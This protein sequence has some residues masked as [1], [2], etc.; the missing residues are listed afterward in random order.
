MSVEPP[1]KRLKMASDDTKVAPAAAIETTD[2]DYDYVVIGGGSGGL[3][4][5]K[6]AA[7]NGAR[8]ALFDF[9]QP[10]PQG[11]KW[12]LGGTCVNVGCIPKKLFHY[13]GLLKRGMHD[14]QHLGWE[15]SDAKL[16]WSKLTE[17]VTD[18]IGGI[19]WAYK[20]AL[21]D[22]NVKYYNSYAQLIDSHTI[23]FKD[24]KV[25]KKQKKM[26]RITA[27]Y[28]L[29]AT[30]GRPTMPDIPGAEEFGI[31][32]DDLFRWE[33]EPGKTLVVGASYIAL[34]CAGFLTEFGYDTTVMVRSILLRGFDRQSAEI[35]GEVMERSGTNFIRP[36]TPSKLEKEGDRI[37]VTYT[38]DGKETCDIFD[39][40]L[41]AT[42]RHP[43]SKGIGLEN[44]G[45]TLSAKG[46]IIT[47]DAEQTNIENIYAIGDVAQDRPE[48][49][50][51]AIKAGNLLADRLFGGMSKLMDYLH[52]PTVVFTP[53]EYGC[54]GYTQEQAEEKFGK[55]N[56]EVYLSRYGNTEIS[57]AHRVDKD[58]QEFI[59][60][61]FAKLIC[62][63]ENDERVVGLHYVGPEAGE[64]LQG[65]ALA[66]KVGAT[67]DDF[68]DLVGIHPTAA[69]E[70]TTLSV[71]LS[72][73]QEW[74]KTGGC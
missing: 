66:V 7:T 1:F 37:K 25:W 35:I 55:D 69:E 43:C 14:A 22:K 36:A 3:A 54:V 53:Y 18:Y 41:F 51:V 44:V 19:N 10:S 24:K 62:D 67:K 48:L 50:P 63:A 23:E 13:S 74:R 45:V 30:G 58:D 38:Q 68:D 21:R 5:A 40:V 11:T 52:V 49:T 72:S 16:N 60:P 2:Y 64:V 34:E 27:K 61:C 33:K 39:T 70:F 28:I 71:S 42:G 12:G 26:S 32:S 31:S 8:V 65:F 59:Q 9:V 47:T 15:M 56:I 20:V 46:K 17:N 57:G 4:S 6:Q 29:I 73:G